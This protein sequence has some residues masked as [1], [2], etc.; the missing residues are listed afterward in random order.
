MEYLKQAAAFVR[1]GVKSF[2]MP[3]LTDWVCTGTG[4]TT[5]SFDAADALSLGAAYLIPINLNLSAGSTEI[6]LRHRTANLNVTLEGYG[7]GVSA[8]LGWSLAPISGTY[9]G[10]E[11]ANVL[12]GM[13]F[14]SGGIGCV[15]AGPKANQIVIS[16]D[17]LEGYLTVRTY[18]VSFGPNG[19]TGGVA[20]FADRPIITLKDL[21]FIKAF[22]L[23]WGFQ[24]VG[25]G[26]ST[27]VTGMVF[28]SKI[29]ESSLAFPGARY[30]A[31]VA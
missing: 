24:L 31:S 25:G 11:I 20:V 15:V 14:P 5:V 9:A 30:G 10:G 4:G 21:I 16:P 1:Q 19:L 3:H 26:V 18:D 27:A 13:N 28:K 2:G 7:G 22:S 12:P 6:S 8:G 29:R 23:V 17:D